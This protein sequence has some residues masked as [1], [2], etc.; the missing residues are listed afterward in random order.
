MPLTRSARLGLKLQ[1]PR[2]LIS[3]AAVFTFAAV[4]FPALVHYTGWVGF[5]KFWLMPWLG[6]H[7][8][9]SECPR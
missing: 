2:V 3:L 4:A 6:Y 1:R 7:F 9:M 8:W 5:A